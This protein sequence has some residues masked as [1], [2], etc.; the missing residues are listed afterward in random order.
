MESFVLLPP[1]ERAVIFSEVAAR[2]S[3]PVGSVEKDFWVC[4]TLRRLFRLHEI[5]THLTFKG[6]TSLSK[7]YRLIERFSEDIDIIIDRWWLGFEETQPPQPESSNTQRKKQV[8]R[9]KLLCEEQIRNRLLPILTD[10]FRDHL[11]TGL[12]WELKMDDDEGSTILFEYP[13][14]GTDTDSAY[15]GRFV[16]IEAGARSDDWPSELALIRPFV[17]ESIPDLIEDA[18]TEVRVILPERTFWDKSTILHIDNQLPAEK[19]PRRN[20][21]RHAYDLHAMIRSGIGERALAAT[22]LFKRVVDHT[23]IF[24]PRGGA[25]YDELRHG[26]IRLVPPPSRI[27]HWRSD[28]ARMREMFFGEPVGFDEIVATLGE[29]EE[30][31]NRSRN[32]G[33]EVAG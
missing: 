15:I 4:W 18:E 19:P 3:L 29:F 20:L 2:I 27:D 10:D 8:E 1:E 5:G 31:F 24:F 26:K 28:Y 17:A 32:T 22:D 23:V 9:L 16:R 6:G 13:I 14:S 33:S 11:P 30:L 7:A 21:S 12:S 25:N